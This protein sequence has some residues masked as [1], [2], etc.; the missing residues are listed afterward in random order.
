MKDPVKEAY[1][2]AKKAHEGQFDRGGTPYI[3]H[4]IKIASMVETTGRK[5]A[6]LLHD[7]CEDCGV[8]IEELKDMGF[9]S[10]VTEAVKALSR[11]KGEPDEKYLE[12]VMTNN[13]AVIVKIA[14]LT[15]NSDLSRIPDFTEEDVRRRERYQGMLKKLSVLKFRK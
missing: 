14:D 10:G 15:H 12:R 2:F 5:T 8:T 11:L 3:E 1:E 13:I 4:P 9:S 7:V 6:A